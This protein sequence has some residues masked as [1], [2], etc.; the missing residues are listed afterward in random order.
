MVFTSRLVEGSFH[1]RVIFHQ[2]YAPPP[3]LTFLCHAI[4]VS[5]LHN[6]MSKVF[7]DNCATFC[8]A[9][10]LYYFEINVIII[11]AGSHGSARDSC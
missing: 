2:I 11:T 10:T 1:C 4:W 7:V 8:V 9:T 3:Y 6:I 5:P